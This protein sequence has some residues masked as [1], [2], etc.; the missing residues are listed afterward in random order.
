M[1]AKLTPEEA[2]LIRPHLESLGL[3]GSA[4]DADEQ[5]ANGFRR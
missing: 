4:G 2:N 1:A 3:M 5:E